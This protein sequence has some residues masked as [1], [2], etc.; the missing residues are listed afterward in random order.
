LKILG[1]IWGRQGSVAWNFDVKGLVVIKCGHM[2]KSQKYG[3]DDKFVEDDV[4]EVMLNVMEIDGVLDIQ[5][6]D[7]NGIKGLEIYT[8]YTG[9]G[10]VRDEV[11][12]S[13]YVLREAGIV[14]EA[15][16]LKELNGGEFREGNGGT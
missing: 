16:I 4:E 6:V 9:W 12:K 8:D 2:Q 7:L 14:K 10:K 1:G 5:E 13:G 11:G 3:E 15:K